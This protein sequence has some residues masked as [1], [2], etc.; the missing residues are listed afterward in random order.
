MTDSLAASPSA[1]RLA[2]AQLWFLNTLLALALGSNY[3]AH[4]PDG[5]ETR[6]W[7]FALPALVTSVTILTLGPGLLFLTLAHFLRWPRLLGALQAFLWTVFQVLL[8]ADTR[9]YNVFGY[10]FNGQV[11]NLLY[12][13][14]SE[15]SIHFGWQ[16]WTAILLGLAIVG[17]FEL[18]LWNRV[19]ARSDGAERDGRP[20]PIVPR[21]ALVWAAVFLPALCVEKTIYAQANLS[22]DRQVTALA[23]LFPLYARVPAEDL[24]SKV[25][26]VELD[27][28]P[29]VEL[30]GVSL[31]YPLAVPTLD[32]SGPRP[33]V[34]ILVV[35][36]LRRDMLGP[37][38]APNMSRWAEGS[39]RFENHISGGNSTRYG[40]FSM[41]YGLYGSYWFPFLQERRSPVLLDVLLQNG[42][43]TGVFSSAT[44]NYP[45]LRD[46]AWSRIQDSV[47]DSYG[48]LPSWERDQLAAD[49]LVAWLAE[50]EHDP[51]PFF[52][53]LLLD[54]PHQTYSY[55][56]GET[57]FTPTAAEL[58][59]MA[60][61]GNDGPD[62]LEIEKVK[63]RYENAVHYADRVLGGIFD[64]LERSGLLESTVVIVTGDHGEE[65]WECGFFGHTSA[66]TPQQVEVPFLMRG[67]GIEPG[68]EDRP[69]SHLDVAPTL[70]EMMGADP[71][72]RAAW[73]LGA[74]LFDPPPDRRR[75]IS[76]W[77]ELGVWTPEGILRVPLS[78]LEFDVEVYDYGWHVVS[79]DREALEREGSTLVDL[80]VACNRFLRR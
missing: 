11:L 52:G 73:T 61:S 7:L 4:V 15:D 68:I 5:D 38:T 9:I 34:L 64:A 3:L 55:P 48:S 13:R 65:F 22:R 14:G 37:T 18:W 44:M 71:G 77:N 45:E 43:R 70:L 79:D 66:Y 24:A 74:N 21:T 10:H 2:A 35:D 58:D 27:R 54:S 17:A 32:P 51:A 1:R 40:I 26:G 60:V 59:Y 20:R 67:P 19:L 6:V 62:P 56:P 50:R 39:R 75:V 33:N 41:L 78:P 25:L 47:H 57:P 69:T 46:T 12:T 23:H 16:V 72:T 76:G 63:N 80:G 8:F 36:C 28:T 31:H 53:F 30:E 42:Y 49:D 29:R